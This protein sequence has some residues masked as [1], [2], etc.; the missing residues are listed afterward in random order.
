MIWHYI[1]KTELNHPQTQHIF[2]IK[3]SVEPDLLHSHWSYCITETSQKVQYLNDTLYLGYCSRFLSTKLLL[4]SFLDLFPRTS[5][6]NN[7]TNGNGQKDFQDL[8]ICVPVP[9]HMQ[10]VYF[11]PF[12]H[13][14]YSKE[15][16][17]TAA[18]SISDFPS[19]YLWTCIHRLIIL[20]S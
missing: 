15:L 8:S 18:L 2:H 1:N 16:K 12:S 17:S 13:L 3:W 19:N 11:V 10:I 14:A 9:Y 7:K 6:F 20:H 4:S 5:N